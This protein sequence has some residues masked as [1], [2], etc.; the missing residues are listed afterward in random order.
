MF[1][2]LFP[3]RTPKTTTKIEAGRRR[4]LIK[5]RR[6]SDHSCPRDPNTPTKTLNPNP[7]TLNHMTLNHM[8]LQ[9]FVGSQGSQEEYKVL[10]YGIYLTQEGG[11]V[12]LYEF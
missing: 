6:T 1:R 10:N 12:F 4:L 11:A 3:G 5:R 7:D 9:G 2:V 8:A